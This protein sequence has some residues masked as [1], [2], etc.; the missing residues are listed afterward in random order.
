M[1]DLWPNDRDELAVFGEDE[2]NVLC[3]HFKLL[4]DKNEFDMDE[5][6]S[7]WLDLKVLVTN[8]YRNLRKH[9]LWQTMFT[10]FGER[11]SNILMLIEILLVL[12][13]STACC[14][15]GFSC[16]SR[17]KAQYRSRMD[18]TTLDYLLRIGIDGV[19]CEEFDPERAIALWWNVGDRARH[20]EFVPN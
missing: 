5:A 18:P 8:G 10:D 17:M 2:V 13:V 3:D 12:P 19:S 11:F 6:L 9:A 1:V 16:M 20:P 4:L 14:E 15:R 7:E